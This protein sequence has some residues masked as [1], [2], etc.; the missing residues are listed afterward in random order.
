MWVFPPEI[1]VLL[2]PAMDNAWPHG[3]DRHLGRAGNNC[4]SLQ[5]GMEG[6]GFIWLER[7]AIQGHGGRIRQAFR[8]RAQG[9]FKTRSRN[10]SLGGTFALLRLVLLFSNEPQ[11][12]P[13]L[14]GFV[15][16]AVTSP[17]TVYAMIK[18]S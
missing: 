9:C 6:A 13:A 1:P 18:A 12:H 14:P 2:R 17:S 7:M 5:V 8:V 11:A 4:L 15:E 3:G 10:P 16:D